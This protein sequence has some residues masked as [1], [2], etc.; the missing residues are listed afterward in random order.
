MIEKNP[1]PVDKRAYS[2]SLTEEGKKMV[3]KTEHFA[4]PIRVATEQLT[5]EEQA[6]L[7]KGLS[8]LIF[9]LNQVGVL[10]VQRT[11]YSCRFYEK[12]KKAD[13]CRLMEKP[14]LDIDICLDCPEYE[15]KP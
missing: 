14:L 9:G 2:I 8:K 13:Y 4:N 5:L 1:S 7:F 11:C 10:T 3:K 12:G 6:Q 15:E